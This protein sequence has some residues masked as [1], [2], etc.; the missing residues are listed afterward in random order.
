ME[1]KDWR[2]VEIKKVVRGQLSGCRGWV[3]MPM[4]RV[5]IFRRKLLMT[6]SIKIK[7]NGPGKHVN[8][9]D[10]DKH[11]Q[12]QTILRNTSLHNNHDIPERLVLQCQHCTEG[13][14]II[15]MEMIKAATND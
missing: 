1:G 8:D 5:G 15:T 12:P 11:L 4:R 10:L 9:V 3:L 2:G 13:K 6:K 7:C 14:V